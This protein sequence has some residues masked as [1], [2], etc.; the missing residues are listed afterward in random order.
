MAAILARATCSLDE[1]TSDDLLMPENFD[2]AEKET[3]YTFPVSS[4]AYI[5]EMHEKDKKLMAEIIK[6]NHKYKYKKIE[7]THF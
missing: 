7:R 4:V 6:D 2:L 5:A 3:E 1:L